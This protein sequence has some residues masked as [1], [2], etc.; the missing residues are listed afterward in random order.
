MEPPNTTPD[1]A[2]EAG[3]AAPTCYASETPETDAIEADY[4]AGL[5]VPIRA[6]AHA[7]RLE[8]E[9]NMERNALDEARDRLARIYATLTCDGSYRKACM[10]ILACFPSHNVEPCRRAKT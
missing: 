2:A 7:R 8:K 6:L 5:S 10:D 4:A 9:R 1:T 3:R